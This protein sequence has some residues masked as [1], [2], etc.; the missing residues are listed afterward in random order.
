MWELPA[1]SA[2][3]VQLLSDAA[4][5]ISS[6][7]T[8]NQIFQALSD[9]CPLPSCL[10]PLLSKAVEAVGNELGGFRRLEQLLLSV[11]GD[12]EGVWADKQLQEVML[13]LPLPAMEVLLASD[14]L[15]VRSRY[16]LW[17]GLIIHQHLKYS[18]SNIREVPPYNQFIVIG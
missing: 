2:T 18:N 12:L 15:K 10:L 16:H 14:N 1:V 6:A 3:A 7:G 4:C 8:A 9:T 13:G 17:V 5:S 11:L